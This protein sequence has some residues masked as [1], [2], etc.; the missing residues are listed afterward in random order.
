MNLIGTKEL[1]TERL[2][3][4]VPTMIEQ[5]RL[6]EILIIPEVNKYYLAVPS[7]FKEKIMNWEKQ[8]P[9]YQDKV[10]HAHDNNK[11]V[12][13]IFLK[14][15]GECIGQIDAHDAAGCDIDEKD[16]G[17][18]I[19]PNY[20]GKGYGTEAA[21][22]MFDYLF[23]DVKLSKIKTGAA[24]INP[25]SW[26]IMEHFGFIRNEKTDYVNY[27]FVTEPIEIYLYSV[28]NEQY[29]NYSNNKK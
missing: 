26:K 9:F 27:T 16:V 19:D 7:K 21:K 5:K 10:N 2:I 14:S 13:S 12:W 6:W 15:T 29:L 23:K 3:L 18:Y 17:W 28:T 22:A 20:Q 1:E 4:K 25:S 11:Y 24:T 8:E